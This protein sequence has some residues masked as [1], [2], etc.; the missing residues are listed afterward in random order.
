MCVQALSVYGTMV[1]PNVNYGLGVIMLCPCRFINCNKCATLV[2]DSDK[3]GG[4]T[5]VGAAGM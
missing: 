4:Y 5:C 3:G 2:G 1:S